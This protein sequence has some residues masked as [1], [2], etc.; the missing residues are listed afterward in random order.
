MLCVLLTCVDVAGFMH[1]WGITIEITSMNIVI[2]SVGLCVDF[3][4]HIMHG[5]LTTPGSR[6][7]RILFIME[8]VAPAVVNGGF[9]TM[10]A[11]SRLV[12]S[13]AH[14]FT[15]FFKIFLLICLFGLFHGLVMLPVLLCLLGPVD[16][17]EEQGEADKEPQSR[18][19]PDK[20]F[21]LKFIRTLLSEKYF[22][23]RESSD[24]AREMETIRHNED[25]SES[26]LEN[27]ID[28]KKIE[29]ASS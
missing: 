1:W 19:K 12:T 5:F 18:H 14:I 20:I 25:V 10:I 27:K 11:L 15:S 8:N 3:C 17:S 21:S 2:I 22:K 29:E 26:L 16:I 6:K 13:G 4:A 7:D 23:T 24:E 28:D 9:S